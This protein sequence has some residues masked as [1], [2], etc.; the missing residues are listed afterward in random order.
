LGAAH[1]KP[2][3]EWLIGDGDAR[4]IYGKP[5][6]WCAGIG[7]CALVGAKGAIHD[8]PERDQIRHMVQLRDSLR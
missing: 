4:S 2:L 8:G 6:A 1:G 3:L 5:V 7:R